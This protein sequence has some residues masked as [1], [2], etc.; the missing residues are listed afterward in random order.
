MKSISILGSTGS[1]GMQTLD[2]AR[3]RNYRV[4]G[5][6]SRHNAKLLLEQAREFKPRFIACEADVAASIGP[7]VPIGTTILTDVTRNEDIAHLGVD[8]VVSA[9][10]GIAGLKPT[11]AALRAGNRVALANKEAMV[12]AGPLMWEIANAENVTIIP[13]D[14]EHSALFQC[15]IGESKQRVAAL[16]LTASGGQFYTKP[17]DLSTVTPSLA[18]H[19][20]N[21]SMGPKVTVD[22]ATLF[23]KGLEVLEAHFLFDVPLD[24]IEVVIHPQ[25]FIH[26]M[27]RFD[28]GSIKAQIGPHDMRIPIQFGLE[29]PDRP[30]VPLDPLPLHGTWEFLPPDHSRFPSLQLAVAAG[31]CG[32]T[33]PTALN[34]AD[35][36]AVKSFLEGQIPFTMIPEVLAYVIGQ[37]SRSALTWDAI[38]D[39]DE[40]ARHVALEYVHRYRR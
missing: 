38:D 29:Y 18:I 33:M 30:P 31:R 40:E 15:M 10:S 11:I 14:S 39:A 21:W 2:V 37:T 3:W 4:V 12:V 16:V 20:P 28:D 25:S 36:I 9:I 17:E 24:K 26:G 19:H 22:T 6:A 23:N 13:L 5:L 34:A 35:E 7:H 27:V 8:T 32:G 1:I